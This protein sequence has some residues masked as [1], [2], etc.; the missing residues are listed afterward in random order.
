MGLGQDSGRYQAK[1]FVALIASAP[2][3][4]DQELTAHHTLL[5]HRVLTKKVMTTKIMTTMG[6]RTWRSRVMG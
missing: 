5:P 1:S 3:S 4:S 6:R 2:R